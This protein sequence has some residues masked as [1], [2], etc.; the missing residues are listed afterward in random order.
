MFSFPTL[1]QL[2]SSWLSAFRGKG[3]LDAATPFNNVVVTSQVMAA[4]QAED[5]A[6]LDFV[7]RQAFAVTAEGTWL[8]LLA[9]QYGLT[10]RPAS[11]GSGHVLITTTDAAVFPAGCTF[12][13][14]DGWTYAS[15]GAY[16][17]TGPGSVSIPVLAVSNTPAA[18]GGSSD[19]T[20]TASNAAPGTPLS[21]GPEST[22]PG[23]NGSSAIV[24]ADGITLGG[25]VETDGGFY[26]TS[27]ATLR[28]RLLFRLR[29][30]PSGG[31]AFDYVQWC[32]SIP[33]V[34]RVYVE[35]RWRGSGTVRV[36]PIFDDLFAFTGGVADSTHIDAV[37]QYL[38]TVIPATA[39]VHTAAPVIFSIDV[40]TSGLT[41][42]TA[43]QAQNVLA[44]LQAMFRYRGRVSGSDE[45]I[46]PLDYLAWPFTLP[47]AWIWQA[48]ANATGT[49][50]FDLVT[51][52]A[53]IVIPAG[54][55]PVLGTLTPH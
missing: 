52:S 55:I 28:G 44:E 43:A 1:A 21:I 23:L 8:D 25:D 3:A 15:T 17:L 45:L 38:Q 48:I 35:R 39:I 30:P 46:A 36:F 24:D 50:S 47:Q 42:A 54:A 32:S 18:I 31:A 11:A 51:P 41:P 2:S 9:N 53:D 13:R 40:T 10:R 26:S 20:G 19:G 14:A 34:T 12:L 16:S 5:F 33:G 4:A 37:A 22:G 29:N 7:G 27:L 6:R 49:Q